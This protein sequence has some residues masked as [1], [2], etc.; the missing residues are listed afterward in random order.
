M[1]PDDRALVD[2]LSPEERDANGVPSPAR[3]KARE[4]AAALVTEELGRALPEGRLRVSPLGAAWSKDLDVWLAA[5]VDPQKLAELGWIPLGG[6]R[7][8]DPYQRWAV[9]ARGKLLA[10]VDLHLEPDEQGVGVDAVLRR[11]VRTGRVTVREVLELRHLRREGHVLPSAHPV[12]RAAA[13]AEAALGG[14][15]LAAWLDGRPQRPPFEIGLEGRGRLR[16]RVGRLAA[17]P[18]VVAVS[19]VDGAGKSTLADALATELGAAGFNTTR[20]WARPGMEMRFV[21]TAARAVKRLLRKG[22]DSAVRAIARGETAGRPPASRRGLV[23]W[24]WALLVTLSYVAK[25]RGAVLR[26][27]GILVFDRHLLDALV[28]LD[29]V[30]GSVDLRLQRTL[31]RALVPKAAITLYLAIPAE[32]A[33]GRKQSAVFGEHAVRSQLELYERRRSEINGLVELDATMPAESIVTEAVAAIGWASAGRVNGERGAR[34]SG[35]S[36][37]GNRLAAGR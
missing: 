31:V 4:Q 9:V 14:T 12:I 20:V 18:V 32:E 21:K 8:G 10:G 26:A 17:R 19:G 24:A 7:G 34:I 25:V 30:Y 35:R 6:L 3:L 5:P 37:T 2:E 36:A 15:D 33:I 28:T 23:G 13:R 22:S 27:R 16:A 1:T 29:F 11:C